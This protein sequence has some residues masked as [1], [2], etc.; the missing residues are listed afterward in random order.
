MEIKT[1]ALSLRA[2]TREQA[3]LEVEH[4]SADDR[5]MVS[6]DWLALVE[7]SGPSDPWIHGFIMTLRCDGRRVGRC[8]FTGPPGADGVAEIAYGVDPEFQGKG[9]ATEAAMGLVE[10]ALGDPRVRII[11]AHT[12]PEENASTRVLTKCGFRHVGESV[13]HEIGICW[14][15]ERRIGEG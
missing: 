3:L 1:P 9:Y 10:F 2:R 6:P 5:R 13:D 12:W 4:L 8:G 15:W 14:R 11:R 7:N